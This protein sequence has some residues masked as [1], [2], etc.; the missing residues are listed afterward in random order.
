MRWV[1]IRWF[2]AVVAGCVVGPAL[3][4]MEPAALDPVDEGLLAEP[5][6][7]L[8]HAL[9]S[10]DAGELE[11]SEK[12]LAAIGARHPVIADYADLERLRLYVLTERF[13][14][15]LA[16]GDGWPHPDSPLSAEV[17][18]EVAR[19]RAARGEEG[20]ARAAYERALGS[21]EDP[22]LRAATLVEIGRSLRRS[23]RSEEAAAR[24]LEVWVRYPLAEVPGFEEDL[25]SVEPELERPLRR[26]ED[27][28]KRGDVLFSARHNEE[29][30]AAY[31]RALEMEG[32]GVRGRRRA[33]RQRARTLYRMRRYVEAREAFAA[34]PQTGETRIAGASSRARSGEV[35]EAAKQLERIA[36][37]VRGGQGASAKLM[38][39][40]LW[41]GE[42]EKAR[43]R[44]LFASLSR[45]RGPTAAT[46]LWQLGW[47][48]YLAG[49]YKDARAYFERLDARETGMVARLRARYWAARAA[50]RLGAPEAPVEFAAMARD[51][52]FSY[53]G[54][55][56]SHRTDRELDE[57]ST[58]TIAA[59]DSVLS[60]EDLARPRILLEAGRTADARDALN[61]LYLRAE[62]MDDRLRLASLYAEAGDY[63][64][65]QLLVVGAYQETLARG[66]EQE[67]I[68]LWWHA[69]PAPYPEAVSVAVAQR[70]VLGPELL[71]AIMRE[72]S[73]Y[74]PDV[75]SVSGARGLLQLMPKTAERV[76][77][78]EALE[79]F[80]VE[81]LFEP[82][83]NIRLG[84]AYLD[85][86]L[87]QF[88]GRAS[89]AIGSYNAGP[90]RVAEWLEGPLLEDDEWVEAI[91]YE[92]TRNYV[93]RV[94]RSIHAYRVLY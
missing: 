43:A 59:G 30:L 74:R 5:G 1:G 16:L 90:H 39:A 44:K 12:L 60:A 50:E 91:P 38:A 11:R 94:L 19:A 54:W 86:L 80:Q 65:P 55:R 71:Y 36:A 8:R 81:D 68:E 22:D 47:D 61:Q 73:G 75:R 40:L 85:E 14:E 56:A 20:R 9:D 33:E 72:E 7:A 67:A 6:L 70:E 13:E 29:A 92:Q 48:A 89:A 27:F 87:H 15:A 88:G 64:R 57:E 51:F 53:Y 84:A 66:P 79:D 10:V 45:G 3:A 24:W 82:Q 28:R 93:K 31:D 25:V 62:G 23:G 2:V 34:L 17:Y 18:V 83:V 49:K 77:R 42:G 32:L 63:H 35:E 46:A 41:D 21:T 78:N 37:E 69:W 26:A 4:R 76:A 52:P 58:W